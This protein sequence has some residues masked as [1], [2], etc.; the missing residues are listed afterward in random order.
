MHGLAVLMG[1]ISLGRQCKGINIGLNP[2][3]DP[4]PA[5]VVNADPDPGL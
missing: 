2:D 3:P 5:F 1:A 4:D